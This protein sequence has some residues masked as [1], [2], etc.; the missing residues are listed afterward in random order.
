MP[1]FNTAI[2]LADFAPDADSITSGILLDMDGFYPEM[3]GY[4]TLPGFTTVG[5]QL[6]AQV[7]GAYIGQLVNA[8][9]V[10]TLQ[11]AAIANTLYNLVGGLWVPQM[12]GLLNTNNRWRFAVYG[13][14]MLAVNGVDPVAYYRQSL[15]TWQVLAGTN[16]PVTNEAYGTGNASTGPFTH[17]L[18]ELTIVPGTVTITASGTAITNEA[19][20]TGNGTAGPYTHTAASIPVLPGTVLIKNT[21]LS[22]Q[23]ATD[24]GAGNLLTGGGV[25][26]GTVN[27]TT[28]DMTLTFKNVVSNGN[29]L[30]LSYTGSQVV[31][32]D[33][34]G[35][36]T[37]NGTGT[38][39]YQTGAASVTFNASVPNS[40]PITVAYTPFGTPPPTCSLVATTGYAVILVQ[41]NSQILFSN[42]S[43]T[44]SWQP[45]VPAQ[46]YKFTINNTEGNITAIAPLRGGLAVY[47]SGSIQMGQFVG[48]FLGWD[49]GQIVSLQVGISGAGTPDGAGDALVNTGDFHYL[50]GPDDFWQ[51]D[52][53][54]LGAIPNNVKEFFFRD[55]DKSNAGFIS[56]RYDRVR[57]LVVWHYPSVNAS[58]AGSLDSYIGFY[59]RKGTWFF[60][61]L[62]V[63]IPVGGDFSSANA[64]VGLFLSNHQLNN[65]DDSAV[66]SPVSGNVFLTTWDVGDR[67][68][69]YRVR[70]VRPGFQLYPVLPSGSG[71]SA[72]APA[73]LTPFSQY[74]PG[75]PGVAP[76]P[77]FVQGPTS[78]IS[79]NGWFNVLNTS[80]VQRFKIQVYGACQLN[81]LEIVGEQAGTR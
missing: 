65:Y 73:K 36:L 5:N 25:K 24:D 48:G 56:G 67:R 43:D 46:V 30:K 76:D 21:S 4:R 20:G 7:R 66:F 1:D 2:P 78:P 81:N 71:G 9:T 60:G 55:L 47:K 70:R 61:R 62:N 8:S 38:I 37:G 64:G 35:N 45:S 18:Q 28:G 23:F 13:Q 57:D 27:Y 75:Y 72:P 33:G 54:N 17:T 39:N 34:S 44:A 59:K 58:P 14:D 29:L 51:F 6:S 26:I 80:T 10:T 32:D 41:A 74:L 15:G 79:A 16:T 31:T 22:W 42:L 50:V 53:Y 11:V 40:A 49:F 63:D 69:Q 19:Y 12:S 77:Q 3:S 52:G 68:Y